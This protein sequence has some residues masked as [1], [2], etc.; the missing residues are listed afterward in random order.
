[1]ITALSR[2]DASKIKAVLSQFLSDRGMTLNDSK[3]AGTPI[4][5]GVDYLGWEI[6]LRKRRGA[7]NKKHPRDWKWLLVIRPS[8]ESVK[9]VRA[10]IIAC[11]QKWKKKGFNAYALT[12]ELNQKL[13][14]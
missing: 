1:M 13:R 14:G 9:S 10:S 5:R 11:F 4:T 8:K 2:D 12:V 7:L 6:R 3:T